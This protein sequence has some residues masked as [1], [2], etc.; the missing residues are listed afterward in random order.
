MVPH[1][2][3]SSEEQ[4]GQPLDE[5]S[6]ESTY[7]AACAREYLAQT[8]EPHRPQVYQLDEQEHEP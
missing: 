1:P 6:R 3:A 2:P 7:R 5:Q 4:A 8:Y